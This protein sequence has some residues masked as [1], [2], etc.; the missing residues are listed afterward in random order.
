M[1][2]KSLP[3]QK[4]FEGYFKKANGFAFLKTQA[5]KEKSLCTHERFWVKRNPSSFCCEESPIK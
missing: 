5:L 2:R 1:T 3:H 4:G